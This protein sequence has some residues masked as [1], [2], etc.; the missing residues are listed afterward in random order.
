MYTILVIDDEPSIRKSYS[1]FLEDYNYS[2][3]EASNGHEGMVLLKE[4]KPDLVLVDLHMPDIDGLDILAWATEHAPNTPTIVCSGT[5]VI[6]DVIEALRLGAWDYI[7][8]PVQDFSVLL[9]A[10]N[11]AIERARLIREN[12]LYNLHLESEV[13]KRTKQVEQANINLLQLNN[14]LRQ[15]V[16]TTKTITSETHTGKFGSLLL[17]EFGLHMSAKGGCLYFSEKNGLRLVHALDPGHAADYIPFP[18]PEKSILSTVHRSGK[19]LILSDITQHTDYCKSGWN[20]YQNNSVLSFPLIDENRNVFGLLSLHSKEMPPFV[21]QDKEVGKI[22]ASFSYQAL[23]ASRATEELKKSEEKFRTYTESA[24]VAIIIYQDAGW[25][26]ANP[27]AEQLMAASLVELSSLEFSDIIHPD[28]R[29]IYHSNRITNLSDAFLKNSHELKIIARDGSEKWV[30]F[31]AEKIEFEGKNAVMVSAM[32]IGDLKQAEIEKQQL[33]IQL[34][35]AQKMESIGTLAGGIAHDFNNILSSVIGYTELTLADMSEGKSVSKQNMQAILRAGERARDLVSQILTFSRQTEK[36]NIPIKMHMIANE[37]LK[38]LRSS[39]PTTIEIIH[40]IQKCK[41]ILADPTQIHQVIMNLCTNAFHAMQRSG[42]VM[43]VTL[44]PI[45]IQAQDSERIADLS[46]G[47]YAKLEVIDTGTGMNQST[48]ER[49]FDPYFTTKEKGKGTGLGLAVVHGIVT[50]HNGAI[51]VESIPGQGSTFRVFLP[52]VDD[53]EMQ[54]T[55]R[56]KQ[57]PRGTEHILL[58]DDEKEIVLIE[59]QMLERLGYK[60]TTCAGSLDALTVF[61]ANPLKFDMIITDMTMPN[62]T[63]DQLACEIIKIRPEI[64]IILCTGFSEYMNNEKAKSM[65]IRKFVLKPVSMEEIATAIR[66]VLDGES[67]STG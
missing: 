59:Q 13:E 15:I 36:V 60:V 32:D 21:D 3:L 50:N 19:P 8:K 11:K 29:H 6:R 4:K 48:I 38:L 22:L 20:G 1:N 62:M 16:E 39:I 49:I 65:G 5:G 25:I 52:V 63:G 58:V 14:R 26:Y 44:S 37:A 12:K 35:Q 43:T 9:H 28:F 41:P 42:G 61:Q 46:P 51:T 30:N 54:I 45:E 10:V 17:N 24:P 55:S 18:L 40:K 2:T 64:P 31:R 53:S 7:L 33:E 66:D 56:K 57:L 67:M 27:A 47:S 34:R 23:R